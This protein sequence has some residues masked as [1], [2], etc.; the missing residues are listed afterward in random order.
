MKRIAVY[1]GSFDPI[2]IGHLEIIEKACRLFDEVHLVVANNLQKPTATFS[3][4]ERLNMVKLATTKIKNLKVNSFDGRML[5]YAEKVK[6]IAIIRGLRNSK[7]FDNELT[8]YY[9]N[10]QMNPNI[11]TV[12]LLPNADSLFISSTYIKELAMIKADFSKYVPKEV[13]T[14]IKNKL[15]KK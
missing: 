4:E 12:I 14:L 3:I 6:A 5:S 1:P 7:D 8:M 15:T 10:H 13:H 11:E 2:T 9:F